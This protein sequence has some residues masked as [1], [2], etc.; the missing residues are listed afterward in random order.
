M[1]PDV[2]RELMRTPKMVELLSSGG[3]GV[4]E[5]REIAGLDFK[6]LAKKKKRGKSVSTAP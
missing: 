1:E 4:I 6:K 5:L 2:F 3:P